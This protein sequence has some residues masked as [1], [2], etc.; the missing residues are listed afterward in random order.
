MVFSCNEPIFIKPT[1]LPSKLALIFHL[2]GGFASST[3][4]EP[5][6]DA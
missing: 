2:N 6:D 5:V 3:D 1:R 4:A